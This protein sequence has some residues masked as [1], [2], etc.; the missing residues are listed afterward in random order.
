MRPTP[1]FRKTVSSY[2][3]LA[4]ATTLI[5][6]ATAMALVAT[7]PLGR[8]FLANSSSKHVI[9]KFRQ[10]HDQVAGNSRTLPGRDGGPLAAAEEDYA[11]RA[12]PAADV[13][14]TATQ[15]ARKAWANLKTRQTQQAKL[16][17]SAAAAAAAPGAWTLYGPSIANFPDILTFSGAP[18]TASG[19]ITALVVD[20]ACNVSICRVWAAAA[21][22]GVWRTDN[23]LASGGP[24]WTFVSGSF[25]T[26]AI[27]TLTYNAGTGTLY[28]GTGEPNASG[29][30]EAGWGIYKSTNGGNSWTLL[31]S[32]VGPITTTAPGTGPNGTYVG[33]AFAGRAVSTIAVDPT[34]PNHLYVSSVRAVRGVSSVG[35]ATSNPTTPRPPFG[36]FES[37]DGGATFNFIWDGSDGP[38]FDGTNP[39]AT[40]R[41]VNRV[42]L[43]PG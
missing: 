23:A 32:T 9:D 33:N 39:K 17:L 10:D 38:V 28:A 1:L 5:V 12:Y 7:S 25:A 8:S 40:I 36:L 16:N 18:Y 11:H 31:N 26:N 22:G 6:S 42:A 34:N 27:G 30:S 41:G 35:G 13:P 19:R 20:P 43:D 4:I 3:R 24:T 15:N 29:D 14:M 37:M 21:G 2:A